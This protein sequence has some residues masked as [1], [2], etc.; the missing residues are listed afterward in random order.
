MWVYKRKTDCPGLGSQR[1]GRVW[2]L[3]DALLTEIECDEVLPPFVGAMRNGVS[4]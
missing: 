3:E 4:I 2:Q 1:Y